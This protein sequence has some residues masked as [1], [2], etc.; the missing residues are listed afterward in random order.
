MI[1]YLGMKRVNEHGAF[2]GLLCGLGALIYWTL[3]NHP[4]GIHE[5]YPMITAVVVIS[6]IVSAFTKR[7]V[8]IREDIRQG[9]NITE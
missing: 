9:F 7:K 2:W 6:L 5:V 3:A 4:F 1:T 8:Q